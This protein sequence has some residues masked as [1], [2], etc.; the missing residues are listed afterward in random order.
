MTAISISSD[1]VL[2]R[3]QALRDQA[4]ATGFAAE[5]EAYLAK[6]SELMARHRVTEAALELAADR[7]SPSVRLGERPVSLGRG[8]YVNARLHLLDACG[9]ACDCVVLHTTGFEGK[10][11]FLVGRERDTSR[12]EALY[13]DLLGQAVAALACEDVPRGQHAATFRRAFLFAWAEQVDRRLQDAN[14]RAEEEAD[15]APLAGADRPADQARA[16]A[17]VLADR[18]RAVDDFVRATYGRVRRGRAP[19]ALHSRSGRAAGQ[20][21]GRDAQLGTRAGLPRERRALGA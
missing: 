8:P 10:T 16:V 6:A 13:T 12:A 7:R 1:A 17:L 9:R 18:R 14:A 19:E 4:G 5:A 15:S 3:I 20:R 21:A 2:R 11:G